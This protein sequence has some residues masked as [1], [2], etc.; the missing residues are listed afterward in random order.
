MGPMLGPGL[1]PNVGKLGA[2]RKGALRRVAVFPWKHLQAIAV[3]PLVV[4]QKR[5]EHR[6]VDTNASLN[7][8]S[9]AGLEGY[10]RRPHINPYALCYEVRWCVCVSRHDTD[11]VHKA[12][13]TRDGRE[14]ESFHVRLDTPSNL[15]FFSGGNATTRRQ[16]RVS[17]HGH[18]QISVDGCQ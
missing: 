7:R 9:C 4:W 15:E 17:Q 16:A 1:S 11:L 6:A 8:Q 10:L 2:T 5:E 18:G 14:R 12:L 13:L 3:V